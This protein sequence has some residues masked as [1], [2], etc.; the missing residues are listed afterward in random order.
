MSKNLNTPFIY[1]SLDSEEEA[2][3]Y[4]NRKSKWRPPLRFPQIPPEEL[5]GDHRGVLRI[6]WRLWKLAQVKK[7][8]GATGKSYALKCCP[9]NNYMIIRAVSYE[10]QE[11]Q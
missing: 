10:E 8:H 6:E 1:S 2:N 3:E 4:A 9:G 5:S 11:M 7:L